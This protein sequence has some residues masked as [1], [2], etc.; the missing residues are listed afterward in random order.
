MTERSYSR[1]EVD[2][3]LEW[4]ET[5]EELDAYLSKIAPYVGWVVI[6][7]NSLE[8]HIADFLRMAILR[9]WFQDERLDVFLGSMMF[10]GKAQALV[11]LYGQ[12][13]SYR[14]GG[15][16]DEELKELSGLLEECAKRRNEYAHADWFGV[17]KGG[18]VRVK[19]KSGRT[20]I[21]HRYR[22]FEQEKLEEDVDFLRQARHTLTEFNDAIHA[23]LS[24]DHR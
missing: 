18:F 2:D 9:D 4:I 17:R 22:R 13:I 10:A 19:L 1:H 7:F 16:T 14:P 23:H 12:L 5:D 24:G 15:K 3:Q 20:G 6:Y 8:D 21:S 11:D